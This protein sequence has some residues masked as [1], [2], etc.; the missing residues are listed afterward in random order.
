MSYD[1]TDPRLTAYALDEMPA[2]ER[3][4]FE[5]GLDAA[6]RAEIAAL[7]EIAALLREGLA[8]EAMPRLT[9]AQRA[10]I[11]QR[12]A[13][14]VR[15]RFR[16]VVWL[17]AAASLAVLTVLFRPGPRSAPVLATR[18]LDKDD[19][20]AKSAPMDERNEP[21]PE[22]KAAPATPA[23]PDS[24][25][26]VLPLAEQPG[27]VVAE[28]EK[29]AETVES[30]QPRPSSR[31]S[32]ADGFIAD[33]PETAPA[34]PEPPPPSLRRAEAPAIA[35]TAGF[36][37][38]AEEAPPA[39]AAP[40]VQVPAAEAA[41]SRVARERSLAAP[42]AAAAPEPM[43]GMEGMGGGFGG[44]EM[45][46]VA[47]PVE[48]AFLA[49]REEPVSRFRVA[50]EPPMDMSLDGDAEAMS[51]IAGRG[52]VAASVELAP[53]PW[54]PAHWL[55]RLTLRGRNLDGAEA[56]VDWQSSRITAYRLVGAPVH[57]GTEASV[58]YEVIPAAAELGKTVVDRATP[59]PHRV[60]I[61]FA[62][63]A[64]PG[65]T[66]R[67]VANVEQVGELDGNFAY[68]AAVAAYAMV[69]IDS[70]LKGAANLELVEKLAR[71]GLGQATEG[72]RH[73]FLEQV[74]Q[75]RAAE[76]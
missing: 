50:A 24:Y 52:G 10:A 39:P 35:M 51:R 9:E 23:K 75:A 25:M 3:P 20:R 74:R 73:E 45:G 2:G 65:K 14:P 5:A 62:P 42:Q 76:R 56:R 70:P 17:A 32:F 38:K 37:M 58:L 26:N 15:R 46:M 59:L 16:W 30:V 43:G 29:R 60:E 44:G 49:V 40:V 18:F 68:A 48:N 55:V 13:P 71:A 27:L 33:K 34:A 8:E 19:A 72:P 61:E 4:A 1:P 22:P 12:A 64:D 54:T 31:L 28:Q 63:Q 6:D 53:C 41:G 66:Q 67:L 57:Q 69:R 21:A 11:Q 47:M 7:R 36:D